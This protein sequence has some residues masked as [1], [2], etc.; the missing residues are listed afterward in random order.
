MNVRNLQIRIMYFYSYLHVYIDKIDTSNE[1]TVFNLYN[2]QSSFRNLIGSELGVIRMQGGLIEL[3]NN[4]KS[5]IVCYK[6]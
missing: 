2:N 4:I 3:E 5:T 1:S 6:R